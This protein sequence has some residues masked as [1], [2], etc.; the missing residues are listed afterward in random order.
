MEIAKVDTFPLLYRLTHP[1]GDANGYKKYR[2]CFLIRITTRSGIEGWGEV[3]DWLP[4]LE[5][6]F[7]ERIIPFLIGKKATD[8]LSLVKII[9]KWHQRSASGVSQ[10]LTEIAAKSAGFSICE[11]WG[12]SWR[13]SIPLYASF[14]SY[15]DTPDWINRSLHLVEKAAADGF[16]QIKVKI[17]GRSFAEDQSHILALQRQFGGTLQVAL[18]A[19]QSYDA[20]TARQW[21]RLFSEWS[22]WLWIEEP[23]PM[24][25]V[26]DYKLLRASLSVPVSGGENLKS[27][28]DFLPLL[29]TR[30]IDILNPDVMH[31]DG[32]D[33]FRESLQLARHF[34]LRVSPHSYDGGLCRL[35]TLFAQACLP[36]W[37]KMNDDSI[38]PVEWDVMENPFTSIVPLQPENGHVTLPQGIGIGIELDL[39]ILEKY[40]WDGRTYV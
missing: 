34:G 1:Y 20:A 11:M 18:D 9:K 8:R 3:I 38:E 24:N 26:Q 39:S 16:D 5:K 10:A 2:S 31:M 13:S 30:A 14:Q 27:V 35:Y 33:G 37:S 12:G 4:V 40:R 29:E 22:N 28:A 15:S 7:R 23:I 21:E 32:I 6:G 36:A 19:N 25:Q 17:G